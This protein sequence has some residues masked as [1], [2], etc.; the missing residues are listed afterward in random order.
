MKLGL[1][2]DIHEHVDHLESALDQLQDIG[3]DR[4]VVIGDIFEMGQ[5]VD[6]TVDLLAA[7]NAMGVWGNHD[8][9]LCFEPDMSRRQKYSKRVLQYMAGLRPRLEIDS[10]LFTHVEPWLDSENVADLWYFDG[11]PDSLEKARRSF[12]AVPHPFIFIGHFHRWLLVSE[13]GVNP[14]A[15]KESI[16]LDVRRRQLV[17]VGALCEGRYAMFDTTT[18][19]LTP[20][21][22][23]LTSSP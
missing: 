5:R 3:V 14:W 22:I 6:A 10:C 2:T 1:L 18:H 20:F 4:I 7:A 11:P 17:V 19:E 21:N 8:F 12:E 9:G 23:Q 13:D 16:T 15:G